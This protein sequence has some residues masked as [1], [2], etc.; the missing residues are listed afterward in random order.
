[1]RELDIG[2]RNYWRAGGGKGRDCKCAGES[3]AASKR[4]AKKVR[5]IFQSCNCFQ[6]REAGMQKGSKKKR[7]I[8][9]APLMCGGGI[10]R[11]E[12]SPNTIR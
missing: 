10:S 12:R 3:N 5:S 7:G 2:Q 4:S 6:R 9:A 1:M 8:S 11:R